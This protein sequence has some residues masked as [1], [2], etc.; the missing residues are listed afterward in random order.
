[1][2]DMGKIMSSLMPLIKGKADMSEVNLII[3]EKLN[4]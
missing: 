3:K 4:N 2:K 1:M